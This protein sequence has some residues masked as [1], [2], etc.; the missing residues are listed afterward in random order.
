MLYN[1]FHQ[2]NQLITYCVR[3]TAPANCAALVSFRPLYKPFTPPM[4]APVIMQHAG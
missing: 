4:P 2:N 1:K 3:Q